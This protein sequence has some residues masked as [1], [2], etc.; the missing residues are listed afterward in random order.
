VQF[1]AT[2]VAG[3]TEALRRR[4]IHWLMASSTSTGIADGHLHFGARPDFGLEVDWAFVDG[5]R[6]REHDRKVARCGSRP[7]RLFC[8]PV[9]HLL[10]SLNGFDDVWLNRIALIRR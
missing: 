3:F 5:S 9:W 4:P 10:R 1:D 8:R 6:L 2:R 7:G